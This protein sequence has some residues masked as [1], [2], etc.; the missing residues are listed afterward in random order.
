MDG[1]KSSTAGG[2]GYRG[3]AR[4]NRIL[5]MLS[6]GKT[7]SIPSRK[8]SSLLILGGH[9]IEFANHSNSLV[10]EGYSWPPRPAVLDTL[11]PSPDN[12]SESAEVQHKL[13]MAPP[14]ENNAARSQE[15]MDANFTTRATPSS[16]LSRQN[17][18]CKSVHFSAEPVQGSASLQQEEQQIRC[19]PASFG[20]PADASSLERHR[21]ET[22]GLVCRPDCEGEIS[23][24]TDRTTINSSAQPEVTKV[25]ITPSSFPALS[26]NSAATIPATSTNTTADK[27]S[28]SAP[29]AMLNSSLTCSPPGARQSMCFSTSDG[30]VTAL[31]ITP[32]GIY[33]IAAFS[34][35]SIRLFDLTM[36]GNTDPEDR[37]GYQIGFLDSSTKSLKVELELGYGQTPGASS[38]CH[39][40]IGARFGST[41]VLVV[42]LCT[43]RAV[44]RRRGFIAVAGGGVQVFSHS[45]SRLRGITALHMQHCSDLN[46]G[47]TGA[48]D[49][50]VHRG[51]DRGD[52]EVLQTGISQAR[53]AIG[54][55]VGAV[56]SPTPMKG[57]EK[58]DQP[59]CGGENGDCCYSV[60]YRLVT[61]RGQ[62]SY[63]VWEVT[64]TAIPAVHFAQSTR[65]P[66]PAHTGDYKEGGGGEGCMNYTSSSSN[67]SG[68]AVATSSEGRLSSP[69][70]NNGHGRS[71]SSDR[72]SSM[73]YSQKWMHLAQANV[74]AP[75]MT[76]AHF[77]SG[78][79]L[80]PAWFAPF[81]TSNGKPA[82][83]DRTF[84]VWQYGSAGTTNSIA[85]A[86]HT[87][88]APAP[89]PADIGRIKS[90][91]LVKEQ[92]GLTS[93]VKEQCNFTE[94]NGLLPDSSF[95]LL[96]CGLNKNMRSAVF[97]KDS[98][99]SLTAPAAATTMAVS[100]ASNVADKDCAQPSS[101][102]DTTRTTAVP[103]PSPPHWSA[104]KPVTLQHS[105]DTF[106]ASADGS[107]WFSGTYELVISFYT[108]DC[109]PPSPSVAASVSPGKV[110]TRIHFSLTDFVTGSIT[111]NSGNTSDSSGGKT[112][113]KAS[114]HL[115]LIS[116]VSC[117]PDGAYALVTCSDNSVLLYR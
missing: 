23:S 94:A 68:S 32:D 92:Q 10:S 102:T 21:N 79:M 16:F 6:Q 24:S 33:C 52:V 27:E 60:V 59:G 38:V 40:F 72:E 46:P 48:A 65:G 54:E 44:H 1:G 85:A 88:A 98:L 107:I 41:S 12:P 14:S 89:A 67:E 66:A 115:R 96:V 5:H 30:K 49:L 113:Q 7:T 58:G 75:T 45:D 106:A 61:G 105:T 114:R 26:A 8:N 86:V 37:F 103:A 84:S 53:A 80:A 64:L 13:M 116:D 3:S 104:S 55:Q 11:V 90:N 31:A 95:E 29:S 77:V 73:I 63:H 91:P 100:S 71:R 35:G 51:Q 47:S 93:S 108:P 9:G 56:G 43:L 112:A 81:T 109:F 97:K 20:N 62:G 69:L 101:T 110:T 4:A 82:A 87:A 19:L 25:S 99:A 22:A 18:S 34:S 74:N 50:P 42:D 39:L 83:P 117:T 36:E 70:S 57:H 17:S 111:S 76:F 78:C 15:N 28:S 2:G